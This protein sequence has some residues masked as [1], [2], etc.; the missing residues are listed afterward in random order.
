MHF[1]ALSKVCA[2]QD[3][4]SSWVSRPRAVRRD[5][6][7][8]VAVTE[9]MINALTNAL[10][11]CFAVVVLRITQTAKRN[12]DEKWAKEK[13]KTEKK[14][15][16]S[17]FSY[18]FE[19]LDLAW[20]WQTILKMNNNGTKLFCLIFSAVPKASRWRHLC[21]WGKPAT[22]HE[23]CLKPRFFHDVLLIDDIKYYIICSP[24]FLNN[25]SFSFWMPK[26]VWKCLFETRLN[27]LFKT[28]CYRDEEIILLYYVR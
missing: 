14:R 7:R 3:Q 4:S 24:L 18:C 25:C 28:K 2:E 20:R 21:S 5:R 8:G 12:A 15:K 9:F 23:L 13:V 26:E 10:V 17:S 6:N 19:C 11:F 22:L 16:K 27:S 1:R